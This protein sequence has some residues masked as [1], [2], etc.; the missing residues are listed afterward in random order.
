VSVGRGGIAA[1]RVATVAAWMLGSVSAVAQDSPAIKGALGT[2]AD[3]P[4][5]S[6]WRVVLAFFLTAGLAVG[7]GFAARRWWPLFALRRRPTASAIRTV[8]RSVLSTSLSA[9]VIEAEGTRFLVVEGRS[10]V[11]VTQFKA[12][13]S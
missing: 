7:L 1:A 9:Y 13:Q 11:A 4:F 3:L 5:P 8:D 2:Q 6:A 12:G 10:G